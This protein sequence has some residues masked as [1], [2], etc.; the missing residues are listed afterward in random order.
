[1]PLPLALWTGNDWEISQT[2]PIQPT[3][4]GLL[5]G[6]GLFETLLATRNQPRFLA[7]HLERLNHS[8]S[9]LHWN[10]PNPS[11]IDWNSGIKRLFQ[12]IDPSERFN[13]IRISLTGGS[14]PLDNTSPGADALAWISLTPF[15]PIES[16]L[17]V[18]ISPWTRNTRCPL[19]GL[20]SASYAANLVALDHARR[21]GFDETLFLNEHGDLC[22]AA[23]SNVFLLLDRQWHTPPVSSGCLPGI[24]RRWLLDCGAC[25]TRLDSDHLTRAEAIVLTSA[26]RGPLPVRRLNTRHL[27][28]HPATQDLRNSWLSAG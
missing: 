18:D 13:R 5:H 23:T 1:M 16:P 22:E 25:E 9:Q 2:L 3:D 19:V 8:A 4:R 20:K 15:Q 24:C 28:P 10:H 14:G 17:A 27:P 26:L 11:K 12:A 6:L 7:W 21:R